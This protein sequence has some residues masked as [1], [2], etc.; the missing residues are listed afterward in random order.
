MQCLPVAYA[1]RPDTV[2]LRKGSGGEG[3]YPY[4]VLV[5]LGAT[6]NFIS[7]AVA[8]RLGLEAVRAGWRKKQKKLPPPITTVN[9]ETLRATVVVRQMVWMRDSTGM[10]RSHA[11]N[12][13]VAD[14]AHYDLI[15]GVAWL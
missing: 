10:K 8:D 1:Y 11:I 2:D 14:I 13:V 6:Y 9:G 4:S 12:F 7:Q 15:L 3:Y 5:D